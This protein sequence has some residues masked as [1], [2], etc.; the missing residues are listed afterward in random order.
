[1]TGEN[2]LKVKEYNQV[3]FSGNVRGVVDSATATKLFLKVPEGAQT[4]AVRVANG[5]YADT[6][7]NVFKI[8]ADPDAPV[9]TSFTP[10]RGHED[11]V[12]IFINGKNFGSKVTVTMNG[13]I[14][15]QST[16]YNNQVSFILPKGV[17]TGKICIK[18][19]KG[20]TGCSEKDFL[21]RTENIN[22]AGS[23]GGLKVIRSLTHTAYSPHKTYGLDTVI[24]STTYDIIRNIVPNKDFFHNIGF[25]FFYPVQLPYPD[26][27]LQG[28]TFSTGY[29]S[30]YSYQAAF[31]LID[32][33]N[34]I[35]KNI[36]ISKYYFS[37]KSA[38]QT[39]EYSIRDCNT[40][41]ITLENVPYQFIDGKKHIRLDAND[42]KKHLT[43][44]S[45]LED[46]YSFKEQGG[47]SGNTQ[48][49]K[50]VDHIYEILPDAYF[51][52]TLE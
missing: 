42:L 8:T 19:E 10:E 47:Y 35:F 4:G 23:Y 27:V 30:P 36:Q 50:R 26:S 6:L 17:K 29:T 44:Y 37:K 25:C 22:C 46:H 45:S 14:E 31:F 49:E 41:T 16:V 11:A 33:T 43:K 38:Q 24:V 13:G 34:K 18:N 9:I 2:F 40:S 28:F 12:I 32:S 39:W 48:D 51:E 21:V 3:W 1:M 5:M 15:F 20:K 52:L 7:K